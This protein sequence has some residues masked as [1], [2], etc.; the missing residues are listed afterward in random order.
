[1]K[2]VHSG[3]HIIPRS[4]LWLNVTRRGQF[5]LKSTCQE[6]LDEGIWQGTT[7]L[8]DAPQTST[9]FKI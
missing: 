3:A 6:E 7:M 8:G 9:L 1:M 5:H 2:G 4:F